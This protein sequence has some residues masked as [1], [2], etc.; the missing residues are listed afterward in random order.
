MAPPARLM[1][2]SESV[3]SQVLAEKQSMDT[4]SIVIHESCGA[5]ADVPSV[6]NR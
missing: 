5:G 4:E 3:F 6:S 1:G 2:H